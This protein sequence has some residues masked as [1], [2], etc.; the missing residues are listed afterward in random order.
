MWAFL[1]VI[2]TV[3]LP[4]VAYRKAFTPPTGPGT[5]VWY[6]LESTICFV[7]NLTYCIACAICCRNTVPR[8]HQKSHS[9]V[10]F[11]HAWHNCILLKSTLILS[12][13][14]LTGLSWHTSGDAV[15]SWCTC[16][17]TVNW[18]LPWV[19]K[20]FRFYGKIV[21]V[22]IRLVAAIFFFFF[23]GSCLPVTLSQQFWSYMHVTQMWQRKSKWINLKRC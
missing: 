13:P 7:A 16:S 9:E 15:L 11:V 20:H 18:F 14:I 17:Q 6:H 21:D 19:W 23:K 22:K 3:L 1:L 10:F 8:H 4:L 2:S 5:G 12:T